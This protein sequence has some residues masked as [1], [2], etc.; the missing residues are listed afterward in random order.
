M[1]TRLFDAG[2]NV[3]RAIDYV[4]DDAGN[5]TQ[6]VGGL[7]PGTYVLDAADAPVNQ[8]TATPSD[9]RTYDDAGNL[10]AMTPAGGGAGQQHFFD[11]H[12]RLTRAVAADGRAHEFR[13]DPLG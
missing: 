4:L 7:D 6:V 10:T 9:A 1:G 13:Y 5:R 2:Q 11:C 8:Y 12:D 3:I